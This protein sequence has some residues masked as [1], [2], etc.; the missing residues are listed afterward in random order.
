MAVKIY[1]AVDIGTY[2]VTLEIFEIS[3]KGI[4][5]VDRIRH[6]LELGKEAFSASRKIG[7]EMVD[8]LCQVLMDFRRIMKSYHVDVYRAIATTALREAKNSLFI[9]G[10]IRH[11]SG[12]DVQ[13]L[14]N[15]EQRFLS[16]KAIASIESNFEEMIRH[17]TA[18]IDVGGGS[19]QIS[20]FDHSELICTQNLQMGSLR[21][22]ERLMTATTESSDYEKLVDQLIS[23]NLRNFKAMYLKDH[24]IENLIFSGADF[25][26]GMLFRD[27]R[28][29]DRAT[30]ILTRE[31]F[32]RWYLKVERKSLQDIAIQNNVSME[33]ASLLRPTSIIYARIV[34]LLNPVQIW[35]PGTHLS[36]GLA[37]EYAE[38]NGILKARH[39]FANDIV[40][41]TKNIARRYGVS[42]PHINNM[43]LTALSVFQATEPLHGLGGRQKLMLRVA[44]MLHDI[45]KYISYNNIGENTYNIIMSNEIIGLTHLEREIIALAGRYMTEEFDDYE[46][47]VEHSSLNREDYLIVA[48]FT[49]IMR[50]ANGLDRSHMQ[51]ITGISTELKK[52]KLAINL[53][54]NSDYVL[55]NS[56]IGSETDFFEEV[57]GVRPV[58]RTRRTL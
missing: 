51:K 3:P 55:E 46:D 6:R 31:D 29:R 28:H 54:V 41:C 14:S 37:Y 43:E 58:I 48:E 20:V 15:S 21:I 35:A 13:I 38:T 17:G 57:F 34:D 56:L 16:Y 25:F 11:T 23:Y 44:V 26:T 10:K 45:G 52:K 49:A 7:P 36:R 5:S 1:A 50:L 47:L 33:S 22:R 40:T 4:H 12:F 42:L 2:D 18:I 32:T 9:L 27:P 24:Q 8:E 53:E 30:R 19:S 39:D